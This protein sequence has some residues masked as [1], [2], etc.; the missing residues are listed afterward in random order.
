MRMAQARCH[1]GHIREYVV[2]YRYHQ[3]GQSADKR[4]VANMAME[5]AR[6]RREC[7]VPGGWLGRILCHYARMKRQ[8]QK[9]VLLGKCDLVSGRWLLRKHMRERTEFS[10]NIELNKL[11][12]PGPPHGF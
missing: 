10:S 5:T 2:R 9:L 7:G 1:V 3:F 4:I 8:V 12:P 11:K 6:I